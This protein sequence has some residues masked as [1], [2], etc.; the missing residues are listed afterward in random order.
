MGLGL[1]IV[2]QLVDELGGEIDVQS[3]P[4]KGTQFHCSF[5]FK[6]PLTDDFSDA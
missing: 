5:P 1:K 4:G 6:L 2:R 3:I